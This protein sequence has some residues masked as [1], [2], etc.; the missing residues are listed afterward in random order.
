MKRNSRAPK[1]SK[2]AKK[3]AEVQVKKTLE[4]SKVNQKCW[5]EIKAK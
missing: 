3:N 1:G 4:E 2:I 5:R